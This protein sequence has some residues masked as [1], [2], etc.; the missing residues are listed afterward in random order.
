VLVVGY[1]LSAAACF[2]FGLTSYPILLGLAWGINGLAQS[3]AYPLHVKLLNPWFRATE[4]GTA[5][6]LWATS[7]QVRGASQNTQTTS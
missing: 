1:L 4:R 7:Q 2:G 6:G 5:M 3:V